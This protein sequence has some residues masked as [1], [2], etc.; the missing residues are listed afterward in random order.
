MRDHY[1]DASG[2]TSGG[3]FAMI[4]LSGTRIVVATRAVD[5]RKGHDGLAPVVQNELGLHPYVVAHILSLR[6]PV[7]ESDYLVGYPR[8]S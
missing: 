3:R 8:S 2:E 4:S 6:H 5:F 7:F 1:V